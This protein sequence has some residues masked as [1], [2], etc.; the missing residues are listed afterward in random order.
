MPDHLHVLWA[1]LAPESDQHRAGAF[2]H[3]F[4]TR[5]LRERGFQLQKQEWDVVLREKDRE[6]GA[7]AN[8][9]FYV[10]ENPVRE[11]LVTAAADWPYSGA[12]APGYPE[13]DWRIADFAKRLWH[14]YD[15]ETHRDG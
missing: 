1:G 10:A 2:V 7:L 15:L 11:K 8:E 6:R 13:F 12:Q 5:A 9:A 4:L 14:I 3:K